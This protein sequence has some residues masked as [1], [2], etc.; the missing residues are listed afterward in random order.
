MRKSYRLSIVTFA[1]L[2]LAGCGIFFPT[3]KDRA[4]K[5]TPGFQNGYSD[6][7]ASASAQGTNYRGDKVR[8]DAAYQSD[9]HYRAGWASGF[10]NCR[11]PSQT[12]PARPDAGPVPD[13]NPGSHPY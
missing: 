11:T 7:C 8:D 10:A 5:Q 4:A 2:S 13:N 9:K 3:A 6:G 12:D 1:A